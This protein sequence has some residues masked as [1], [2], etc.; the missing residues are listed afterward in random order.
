MGL[1]LRRSITAIIIFLL[2]LIVLALSLALVLGL[3]LGLGWILTLFLPFTL[4]EASLLGIIA[5]IIVGS[6][7]YNLLGSIPGLD[8]R[9][10][11][12]DEDYL[13][14]DDEGIPASKFYKTN[15]GRTWE[16]WFRYQIANGIYVEFQDS[17]SPVAPLGEKQLQELAIRLADITIALLKARPSQSKQLKVTM[18]TV[19]RQMTKMG[20]RPYDDNILRLAITAINEDLDYHYED[21]TEV[22]R[23]RLWDQPCDMFGSH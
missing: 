13:D 5:S 7:W 17:P 16:A 11:L 14:F 18:S 9:E 6:V 3:A 19:K 1:F 20:Q 12:P 21:L 10:Y 4:F 8:N 22:I 2:I 23:A 15:A